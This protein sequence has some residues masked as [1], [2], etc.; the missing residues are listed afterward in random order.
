MMRCPKL[1]DNW[2]RAEVVLSWRR[3]RWILVVLPD[4]EFVRME[5]GSVTV[6]RHSHDSAQQ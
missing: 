4:G 5:S 3:G 6:L 2:R 1:N